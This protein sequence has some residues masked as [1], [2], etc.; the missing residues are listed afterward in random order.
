M[1]I[2]K[3]LRSHFRGIARNQIILISIG[4]EHSRSAKIKNRPAIFRLR[5]A[6]LTIKMPLQLLNS[7]MR[8]VQ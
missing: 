8:Y 5:K 4:K 7:D 6:V 2:F 3:Y 1:D